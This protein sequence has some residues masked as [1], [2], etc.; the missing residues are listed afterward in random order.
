METEQKSKWPTILISAIILLILIIAGIIAYFV[1]SSN[2][3][4]TRENSSIVNDQ[5]DTANP[6]TSENNN[7]INQDPDTPPALPEIPS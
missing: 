2:T 4:F 3:N 1:F 5:T 7:E 6:A